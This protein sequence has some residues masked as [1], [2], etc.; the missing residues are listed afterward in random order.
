MADA[1]LNQGRGGVVEGG[2]SVGYVGLGSSDLMHRNLDR[3]VE[4]LVSITNERHVAQI[5]SLFDLAFDEDTASWRLEDATWT[6]HSS[7]DG[8]PLRDLQEHLIKAV[9]ARRQER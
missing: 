2:D 5:G 7:R 1:V 3:R 4:V 6:R 9:G 8:V